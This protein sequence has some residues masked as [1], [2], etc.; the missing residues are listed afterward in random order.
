MSLQSLLDL[1]DSRGLK[2]Q[3]LSEERLKAQL[4]HLR[5][6]VSFYR[7]YP[8]YLIDFMKGPDSTFNFY[9]YQRVFLRIVMRHR[10][11]YATFPRAYSKSFL[12]M[13]VLMLRCILYP[14]SHLFVTTGG[15]EQAA[16][17]TIAKIEEICKLIPSLNNEIDWT[18]G[19][20]KK[21]KDDV[22][23]IFKN[24][25]SIDILAAKQSSR[26]Q[27]RTGGLMEECVLIDGDILNE[28]IIPTTNVDRLLPDGTRHKEEVIN[29]SQ[30]YITTAGWKNSFAYDKLIELLIQSV[31]EPD[32]VMIMGGTYE[33]PITERLLDEDFLDQLKLHGTFK[34]E[35][36]DREYRS[37]WSG[38]A[39][40]AFYSSEKFDKHRVLLQPEYEYSGRS[41]KNAYYVL[42]VDVGR[43]GCT[44][45]VC[46][47]KVTPQPQG[48]SLKSLVHIYTY[49]AEHFEDQAI[50]IKKL[51]YKYK[52]RIIS[53]DANG[54]GI[55]LVDFMVKS[56]VDP[57]SGD[58]LPP[59]G[60]E[61]GTSEDAVEPYKKIKGA[62]VEE[63]ALYL[64]K[65]NAPINT[66]AYSYAQTQLSSGKI[67]FLIDESMA[68][69]K[70]MSTKVG[71]NMDS[72]KRNEFLKPF[73]LTSILREQMLN[74]VEK[75]SGVNIILEQSSKSIKK[76]KFSA[77]IYGLYY[78]KQE[79]DNKRK[80][81]KRHISDFMFMN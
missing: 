81:R 13:M 28:V 31:I 67:K 76:D 65:A 53:I 55:G 22:K 48:T 79:E 9:F 43:I 16:S 56:Q 44:T 54:L 15:K 68:K 63:N 1:S 14:N 47:F 80:R 17:I 78:I 51:Y 60:V 52:A 24:S 73:T 50:H 8:D 6:L 10:Y 21:S 46:V 32:R 3:G 42:G 74:L 33:T 38:D 66:E 2:K 29:K 27:R 11:V 61:G 18:R 7:E 35:S 4:P 39:E 45:E 77:F 69:T 26:G 58:S 40:N 19:A 36:F 57:E 49:E 5:N 71:Q 72:D 37:L 64:I 23:Y 12:S 30:I 70:L 75:N 59:F 25:S 20:S 62:D 41:S 34:E